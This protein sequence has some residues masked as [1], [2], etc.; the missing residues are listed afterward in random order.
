MTNEEK[1][2]IAKWFITNKLIGVDNDTFEK[3]KNNQI[4]DLKTLENILKKQWNFDD[5]INCIRCIHKSNDICHRCENNDDG[6]RFR[7]K[8]YKN[9]MIENEYWENAIK[10]FS[11]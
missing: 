3:V 10:D 6:F 7:Y 9:I 4:N 2:I 1:C 11:I 5:C 8:Y